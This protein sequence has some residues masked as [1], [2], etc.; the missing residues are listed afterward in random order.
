MPGLANERT[1]LASARTGR[2][3][4]AWRGLVPQDPE[5]IR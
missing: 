1:L 5:A 2:A 3:L 4:I